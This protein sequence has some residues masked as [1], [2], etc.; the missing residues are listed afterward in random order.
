MAIEMNPRNARAY[1]NRGNIYI[2]K[3]QYDKAMSDF[4]K[5][6]EIK[7]KYAKAYNNRGGAYHRKGQ[8]DKAIVDYT[9]A[10][11]IDPRYAMAYNNRGLAYYRKE[12]YEKAWDDVHKAQNLGYKV[13]PR[14]LKNLL[15]ASGLEKNRFVEK[16][17]GVIYD[18]ETGLEWYIGPD[19]DMNWDDAKTWIEGLRVAGKTW[20]MPEIW[21]LRSLFAFVDEAG[22]KRLP[23]LMG[24]YQWV[25]SD[26]FVG[27]KNTH[28]PSCAMFFGAGG[29]TQNHKYT[30]SGRRA[31]AVRSVVVPNQQQN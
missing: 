30:S 23:I 22:D 13:H 19:I 14:F 11:E 21:E 2:E 28:F 20:R 26:T 7:P 31:F 15:Q 8:Y 25:W 10:I 4:N 16:S 5:A 27:N 3:G 24:Q 1:S 9:K 12:D 29:W 18:I 17:F 6:I